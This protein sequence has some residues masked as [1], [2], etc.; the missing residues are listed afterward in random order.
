MAEQAQLFPVFYCFETAFRSHL[1]VTL[2]GHY[3]L[4][5]W[6]QPIGDALQRGDAPGSVTTIQGE[7]LSKD[8]A[9]AIGAAV[10]HLIDNNDYLAAQNGYEFAERCRFSQIG[11]IIAA[12]WHV[13]GPPMNALRRISRAD[14]QARF[15]RVREARNDVYHHHSLS[16]MRDVHATAED[17]LDRL[18][19]S[20]AASHQA[21]AR[22]RP[23]ALQFRIA[24]QGRHN[25][26]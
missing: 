12:H 13:F 7:P 2:E 22:A 18:N 11:S 8:A 6:W 4:T 23:T 24:V 15:R 9:N 25:A 20:L 26:P 3:T 5:R 17:L 16:G 19:C 21:V 1:A 14:F 10:T